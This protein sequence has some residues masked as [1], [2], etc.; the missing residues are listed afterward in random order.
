M[1]FGPDHSPS[2][3]EVCTNCAHTVCIDHP[4]HARAKH[5][6][7][8]GEPRTCAFCGQ[9]FIP[10]SPAQ[11]C[12]PR[13]ENPACDDERF[14]SSL[15]PMQLIRFHGYS[16]KEEFIKDNGQD[17]WETLQKSQPTTKPLS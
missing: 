5:L 10:T 13:E 9:T 12:C 15:S 17:A 6:E 4:D 3:D 11:R 14:F 7:W 8:E 1:Y 16:S 2:C